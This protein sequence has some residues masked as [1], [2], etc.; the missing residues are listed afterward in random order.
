MANTSSWQYLSSREHLSNRINVT[1]DAIEGVRNDCARAAERQL[2]VIETHATKLAEV[3]EKAFSLDKE[4]LKLKM[5]LPAS[6]A[7]RLSAGSQSLQF[8]IPVQQRNTTGVAA[9]QILDELTE[10][11]KTVYVL[12]CMEARGCALVLLNSERT[13]WRIAKRPRQQPEVLTANSLRR[14][15]I[16]C[17]RQLGPVSA[18]KKKS[19]RG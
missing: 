14:S 6:V 16:D 7:A 1:E 11:L 17:G 18:S 13:R 10:D 5:A 12:T 9:D 3:D 2:S 15:R 19:R 4:V 8:V